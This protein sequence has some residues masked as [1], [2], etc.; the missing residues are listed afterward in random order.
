MRRRTQ[1][2]ARRRGAPL[3]IICPIAVTLILLRSI[4]ASSAPLRAAPADVIVLQ[5]QLPEPNRALLEASL[6]ELLA[7]LDLRLVDASAAPDGA[8]LAHVTVEPLE[9][10]VIVSVHAQGAS[11]SPVRYRV[12]RTSDELLSET[13]AHVILGAVE[14]YKATLGSVEAPHPDSPH[15]AARAADAAIGAA[16][17]V[18]PSW[19]LGARGGPVLSAS[20]RLGAVFGVAF[21]VTLPAVWRPSAALEAAYWV[22][23]RVTHD[24]VQADLSRF[25]GRLRVRVEP[26]SGERAA[27]QL[28]LS[29]GAELVALSP[30]SPSPRAA[31]RSARLQPLLGGSFAGVVRLTASIDVVAALGLDLELAPRRWVVQSGSEQSS[32]FETAHVIPSASLGFEWRMLG[33]EPDARVQEPESAV[34]TEPR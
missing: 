10:A 9:G 27:L 25:G 17:M 34:W 1:R 19:W 16:A 5:N 30:R 7:R 28:G 2:T 21:G 24:A 13:L 20:D 3:G 4:A 22:P 14:P 15:K 33:G 11:A 6:R 32:F 18:D 29:G 26:L 23:S 31:R 8:T 12:E